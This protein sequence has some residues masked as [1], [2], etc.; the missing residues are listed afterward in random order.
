MMAQFSS[1]SSVEAPR[2]GIGTTFFIFNTFFIREISN[3]LAYFSAFK[4]SLHIIFIH[5][6][7][8]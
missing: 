6:L 7:T 5:W 3:E 8:A 2:C 4:C 1:D